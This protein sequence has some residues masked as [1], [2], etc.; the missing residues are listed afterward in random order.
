[1]LF[2]TFTFAVFFAVVLCTGWLL[3]S[4][5]VLWKLFMVAASYVFYAW[6][7]P[8][9]VLLLVASTFVNTICGRIIGHQ[10]VAARATA[11]RA[12]APQTT[13][14]A[15]QTATN[16]PRPT[17]VR[18]TALIVAVLY[19]LGVLGFFKYHDFFISSIEDGLQRL[20]MSANLPLLRVVLPVGISFFTFQALSYVIDIHRGK[21]ST[22]GL[23][24]FAV[25]LSFFPQLVAGPIVRA[26]EFLPQLQKRLNPLDI[27]LTRATILIAS[28]LFKKVV[29]SSY[30]AEALVDDVF[31]FPDRFSGLEILLAL[32]G[33]SIQ[34]YA[35]FSGYTD[36]AIGVAILLGFRFPE[37]FNQP[38]RATSI[39]DFWRRWHITLSSWL[40]DY[41]YIPLGGNRGGRA[42]RDRNLFLT[43]LLGGLWH[44]AAWP[45]VVWGAYQGT[46]LLVERRVEERF[47]SDG[48]DGSRG[49]DGSRAQPSLPTRRPL[50]RR[51][52]ATPL[53]W[54][55]TFHFV[56][57]GW[58]F[59][60]SETLGDAADM[61]A[62]LFTSFLSPA[63]EI[64]NV[65]VGV[66]VFSL[67]AQMLSRQGLA[68]LQV[69]LS[70]LPVW[71]LVLGFGFWILLVD[72]LG[73][74]GV[75]PFIYFQF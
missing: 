37:N 51:P 42:K 18:R 71:W 17:P 75:A 10:S 73:P 40:R 38:Y 46:G 49:L 69:G 16:Q 26:S 3:H 44:G 31:G 70:R 66:I 20:G 74:E 41:L 21:I 63:P 45:F 9:F 1:M 47:G 33:Y 32:Y 35:D 22:C 36:I 15:T 58:L 53:R 12:A 54:L 56:C 24:D 27:D 52:L 8:R 5:P 39:G 72:Q 57:V 4:K 2:P 48:T 43:M 61:I 30:L 64:N 25:Y 23:L 50:V 29:I 67:L 28:G 13:A 6:W 19:N 14:P 65:F 62:R 7:N 59:F 34:I 68:R 60:R 55:I 11:A